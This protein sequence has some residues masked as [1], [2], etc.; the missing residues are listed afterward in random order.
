MV[1]SG[2]WERLIGAV[3]PEIKENVDSDPK[4]P[5]YAPLAALLAA[6]TPGSVTFRE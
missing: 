6:I 4:R 1:Q 5:I 3:K 2:D